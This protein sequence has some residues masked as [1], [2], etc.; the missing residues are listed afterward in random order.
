MAAAVITSLTLG[1]I[2][3]KRLNPQK[4][5]YMATVQELTDAA[6]ALNSAVNRAIPIISEAGNRIDPA[7]LDPVRDSLNTTAAALVAV[8]PPQ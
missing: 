7:A 3:R 8:L 4:D 1:L 5:K 2:L 6:N